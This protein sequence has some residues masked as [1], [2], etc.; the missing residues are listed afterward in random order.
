[1]WFHFIEKWLNF[2]VKLQ[3]KNSDFKWINFGRDEICDTI[4]TCF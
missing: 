3:N 1:M 2:F 4:Y